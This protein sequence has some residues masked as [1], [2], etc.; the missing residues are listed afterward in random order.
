MT[1]NITPDNIKESFFGGLVAEDTNLV[2]VTQS[3]AMVNILDSDGTDTLHTMYLML[4]S[5]LNSLQNEN[6][7]R[8][9]NTIAWYCLL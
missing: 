1:V 5:Y 4:F 9:H 7:W 6:N 3:H 2:Q 8:Y